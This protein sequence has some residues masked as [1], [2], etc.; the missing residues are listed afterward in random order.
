VVVSL[1]DIQ[2]KYT[3]SARA[4]N[5]QSDTLLT[6]L[7]SALGTGPPLRSKA[8]R[9]PKEGHAS[10]LSDRN[11]SLEPMRGGAYRGLT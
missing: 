10:D 11:R 5:T 6:L 9:N 1:R 4:A 8:A 2:V 7:R 3:Q